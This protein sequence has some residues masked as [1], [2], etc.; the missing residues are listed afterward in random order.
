[1]E[2]VKPGHWPRDY[3]GE[4]YLDIYSKHLY[5]KK[6]I[7]REVDFVI[8][9]LGLKK[10][11]R[12]LDLACGFGKHIVFFLRKGLRCHGLDISLPYLRYAREKIPRSRLKKSGLARGDM[13]ALPFMDGCFHA[14]V[15]LFNS[16]G[17][18]PKESPDPHLATLREVRRVLKR[19]GSFF[20]EVPNKKPVLEMLRHTPQT[21]QCGPHFMIHELWDYEPSEKI[22][23]NKSTFNIKGAETQA[24]Y[25]LRLFTRGEMKSLFNRAGLR[26]EKCFGDYDGF[27]YSVSASPHLIAV[28]GKS[29]G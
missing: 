24:G 1:M 16:F 28:G 21:L 19:G 23:Y 12:I 18:F 8:N 25:Q 10:N 4:A 6:E 7:S 5:D 11:H 9:V 26:L 3:F 20:L 13:R 27:P 14:V 17:Y 29:G 15:C 22:L 2:H